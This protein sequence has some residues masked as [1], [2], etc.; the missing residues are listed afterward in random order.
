MADLAEDAAVAADDLAADDNARANALTGEQVDEH[1]VPADV[2][3]AAPFAER[4]GVCIVLDKDGLLERSAE[5]LADVDLLPAGKLGH[6]GDAA[7]APEI[8]SWH[9]H[10]D[11]AAAA[12]FLHEA[13]GIEHDA[14][15]HGGGPGGGIELLIFLLQKLIFDVEDAD[16]VRAAG[17]FDGNDV[18]LL[19]I[20]PDADGAAAQ[21][22]LQRTRLGDDAGGEKVVDDVGDGGLLQTRPAGKLCPRQH[23]LSGQDAEDGEAVA[24]LNIQAVFSDLSHGAHSL[25]FPDIPELF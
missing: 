21:I 10:A 2:G 4:T 14:L 24:L 20:N 11:S 7:L 25:P 1:V 22:A 18:E 17:D 16:A 5:L 23:V 19:R 9:R 13:S 3:A 15:Q 8:G 12:V 6:D